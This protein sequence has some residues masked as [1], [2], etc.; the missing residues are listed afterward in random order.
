MYKAI[1]LFLCIS[2]MSEAQNKRFVYEYNFAQDS[3]HIE[4]KTKELL[5]LDI[6]KEGSKFYAS[7]ILE[8]DSLVRIKEKPMG[9]YPYQGIK[10]LDVVIKKDPS[11][12]MNFYTSCLIYYNASLKKKLEWQILPE[13]EKILGYSAQKATTILYKRKWTVWFTTEIPIQDGLYLFQGLPGLIIKAEDEKKSI[14]FNLIGIKSLNH[15]DI[16]VVPYFFRFKTVQ[17]NE[18]EFKTV[19]KNY[20]DKPSRQLSDAGNDNQVFYLEG[21]EV[22][23]SEFYRAMEQN[24]KNALKK[25]NNLLRYDI[26]K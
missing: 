16:N 9:K 21:K 5:N 25:N 22:S 1:F 14:S 17:I 11:F 19:I 2:L 3:T 13:K 6:G 26:I 8:Q 12:E 7:E 24:N 18:N 10:F 4:I 15:F 23:S 20:F